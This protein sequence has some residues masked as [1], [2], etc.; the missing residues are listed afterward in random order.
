MIPIFSEIMGFL[1]ERVG[2]E[3][4]LKASK[5]KGSSKCVHKRVSASV[6]FF[7]KLCMNSLTSVQLDFQTG[8]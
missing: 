3:A 5:G 2:V 4:L 7:Q 8:P 6:S 1:Q